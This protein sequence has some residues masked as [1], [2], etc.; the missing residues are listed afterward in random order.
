MT[1][2]VEME[3]VLVFRIRF[4]PEDSGEASAGGAM[5]LA[6]QSTLNT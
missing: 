1:A 5:R 4:R 3:M 6:Q 2:Q